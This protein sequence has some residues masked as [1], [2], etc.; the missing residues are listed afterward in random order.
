MAYA[1]LVARL[2][3][4]WEGHQDAVCVSAFLSC[5][6]MMALLISRTG[7]MVLARRTTISHSRALKGYVLSSLLKRG[8]S[9]MTNISTICESTARFNHLLVNIPTLNI[10]FLSER[11]L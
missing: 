9:M 2:W 1:L 3:N 7:K 11:K 10:D 4:I 5:H 6:L 8:T